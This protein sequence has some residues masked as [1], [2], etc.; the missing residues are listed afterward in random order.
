MGLFGRLASKKPP[1]V[2]AG[3][4]AF[5]SQDNVDGSKWSVRVQ[6]PKQDPTSDCLRISPTFHYQTTAYAYLDWVTGAATS[7]TYPPSEA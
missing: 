5:A 1:R 4:R 7:F 3:G 2:P 6:M